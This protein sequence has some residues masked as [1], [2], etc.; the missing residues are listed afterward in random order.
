MKAC[1]HVWLFNSFSFAST[2]LSVI[3]CRTACTLRPIS[4]HSFTNEC[5]CCRWPSD[6]LCM[7]K[8]VAV[9]PEGPVVCC[10]CSWSHS[11]VAHLLP[12]AAARCRLAQLGCAAAQHMWCV[13][14][15]VLQAGAKC[16]TASSA[17]G[18][19][20]QGLHCIVAQLDYKG[21]HTPSTHPIYCMAREGCR[22][23]G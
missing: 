21:H 13:V 7:F 9:E 15:M 8:Q 2:V 4:L 12:E 5:R 6:M 19:I 18:C 10:S 1:R 23:C 22:L 20:V 14:V 17:V 11:Y 3:G 16:D